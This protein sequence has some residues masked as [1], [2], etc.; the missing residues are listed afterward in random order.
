MFTCLNEPS[1][2]TRDY[3]LPTCSRRIILNTKLPGAFI[4]VA[5]AGR[6]ASASCF[7]QEQ[8]VL[9][10]GTPRWERGIC[11]RHVTRT[12][13]SK[14]LGDCWSHHSTSQGYRVTLEIRMIDI[15]L[16]RVRRIS[17]PSPSSSRDAVAH[18]MDG[19]LFAI[20][21][22]NNC[23]SFIAINVII[24]SNS[25]HCRGWLIIRFPGSLN[26]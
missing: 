4:V 7:D 6:D 13:R 25:V 16:L 9:G 1:S 11:L 15:I 8:H 5:A 22:D 18:P 20:P 12:S 17:Q 23:R 3:L 24:S 26:N 2:P 14:D 19:A 21:S 10:K